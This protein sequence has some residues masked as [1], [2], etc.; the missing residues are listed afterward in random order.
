MGVMQNILLRAGFIMNKL[1]DTFK[2]NDFV[3]VKKLIDPVAVVTIS[4]YMEHSLNQGAMEEKDNSSKYGRYA[5]PLIEVVLTNCIEDIESVVGKKL[6]ETYSYMRVYLKDDEL[7]PHTDRPSCEYSV[8]VNVAQE[9]GYWPIFMKNE[10]GGNL[11]KIVLNPGDAVVYKGCTVTHW[12]E[13]MEQ[14][15]CTLNAQFMLHYVDVNGPFSEYKFDKRPRL[16]LSAS[17]RGT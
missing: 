1:M 6:S 12:R 3:V 8:T 9:G 16:G 11:S 17:T 10:K 13:K 15:E 14:S 2:A 7:V 4:K 5:D